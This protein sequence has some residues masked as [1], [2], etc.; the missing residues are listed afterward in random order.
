MTFKEFFTK[1]DWLSQIIPPMGNQLHYVYRV[2]DKQRTVMPDGKIVDHLVNGKPVMG[3][4]LGAFILQPMPACCGMSLASS[5]FFDSTKLPGEI[6]KEWLQDSMDKYCLHPFTLCLPKVADGSYNT[7]YYQAVSEIP[8]MKVVNST[9]NKNTGR[10]IDTLTYTPP[11]IEDYVYM[12]TKL[13]WDDFCE[14]R[15]IQR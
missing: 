15:K 2:G 6:Y 13:G 1:N 4:V 14:E 10:I 3:L 5:F 11:Q 8:G 9:K 12:K 7:Y